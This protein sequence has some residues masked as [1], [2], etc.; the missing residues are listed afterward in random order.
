MD[1][2][3]PPKGHRNMTSLLRKLVKVPKQDVDKAEKAAAKKKHK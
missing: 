1:A 3:D 2:K